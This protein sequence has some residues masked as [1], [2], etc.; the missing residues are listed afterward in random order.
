MEMVILALLLLNAGLLVVAIIL[1]AKRPARSST[2]SLAD[3]EDMVGQLGDTIH[4]LGLSLTEG[5]QQLSR[6]TDSARAE[7]VQ[8]QNI[9]ELCKEVTLKMSAAGKHIIF[10][11]EW[12]KS[13]NRLLV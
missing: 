6:Q 1:I 4:D 5:Q 12:S 9:C 10:C 13:R 2:E 3:I 7:I 11:R 8:D